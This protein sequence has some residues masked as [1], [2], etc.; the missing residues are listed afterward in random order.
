MNYSNL[1]IFT[2]T[3]VNSARFGSISI[4]D[5]GMFNE[6]P[7]SFLDFQVELLKSTIL[8]VREHRRSPSALPLI[9][10]VDGGGGNER[11]STELIP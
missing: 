10:S 5:M 2:N 7:A 1:C 8:C 9:R 3:V 6:I 11:T 4:P